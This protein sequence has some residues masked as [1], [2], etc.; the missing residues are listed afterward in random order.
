MNT[1]R[2]PPGQVRTHASAATDSAT[3]ESSAGCIQRTQ[4]HQPNGAGS[5]S[6]NQQKPPFHG[7]LVGRI[8]RKCQE[9]QWGSTEWWLLSKA[10]WT[11]NRT[12]R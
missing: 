10:D 12:Y 4:K 3:S 5:Q 11:S 6:T 7:V 9:G 2:R 8:D 1:G